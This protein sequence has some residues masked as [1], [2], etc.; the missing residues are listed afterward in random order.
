MKHIKNI[1]LLN[2]LITNVFG[3]LNDSPKFRIDSTTHYYYFNENQ[4]QISIDD[5]RNFIKKNINQALDLRLRSSFLS[6][7]D[8][9]HSIHEQ[10]YNN[11]PIENSLFFSRTRNNNLISGNG[12]IE[13]NIQLPPPNNLMP[14]SNIINQFITSLNKDQYKWQDTTWENQI[15]EIK[16]DS[17][18]TYFPKEELIILKLNDLDF[19]SQNNYHYAYKIS[20]SS[21]SFKTDSM[22]SDS[23]YYVDAMN[24]DLL[25]SKGLSITCHPSNDIND[26]QY[27]LDSLDDSANSKINTNNSVSASCN[28]NCSS[29]N[30]SLYFYGG[31][32]IFTEHK[33]RNLICTYRLH[34]NCTGSPLFVKETPFQQTNDIWSTNSGWPQTSDRR[35]TTALWS[36]R[37]SRDYYA[38]VWGRNSY[39]NQNSEVGIV[40]KTNGNAN[41]Q[42]SSGSSGTAGITIGKTQGSWDVSLD[43]I[44]HEFSHGINANTANLGAS[45]NDEGA[46]NEGFADIF[47]EM[48]EFY[49]LSRFSFNG[50]I[51]DYI[52]GGNYPFTKVDFTRNFANPNLYNQ[53]S[54][55]NGNYYSGSKQAKMGVLNLWFYLLA[56]SGSGTN[57]NGNTYCVNGIGR[58]KA[59]KIAY[60]TLTSYIGGT[61]KD[62]PAA[63]YASIQ[64]AIDLYGL[65]SPEVQEVIAAWYAVGVGTSPAATALGYIQLGNKTETSPNSYHYNN[66]L[67][68]DLYTVQPSVIVNVSSNQEIVVSSMHLN[69]PI[70]P[71][72]FGDTHFKSGS[73]THLYIAPAC[74]GGARMANNY[75]SNSSST[76]DSNI[77]EK[78]N[79][80]VKAYDLNI[81]PNPN[82]G[83]FT[84][85]LDNQIELPKSIV[86]R[87][88]M[89]KEIKTI[90]N[91][92]LY[93]QT[94]DMRN[95]NDGLYIIN[96]FYSDKTISKRIVKN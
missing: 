43:I 88:N 28:G 13:K 37:T 89:G 31:K 54:T 33:K 24:G 20:I 19:N 79:S 93:E 1:I 23:V 16:N 17:T 14:F 95:L 94:F 67:R 85:L 27:S 53:A 72:T 55:Y 32:T 80:K 56:E 10:I 46:I 59:E 18:A 6:E 90:I 92:T 73:E 41:T 15:K 47:G 9:T 8:L 77:L 7:N 12:F 29:N 81:Y 74:T 21:L 22:F 69:A 75:N 39:D 91:P 86:V 25:L 40:I 38:D 65:V 44:G 35:G 62:F 68:L 61:P 51:A 58:N 60:Y 48:I 5:F 2:L 57:D 34:D 66:A 52:H 3:Q 26:I 36:L 4:Q 84:L 70:Y 78:N 45:N 76:K 82:S 63:R 11:I 96:V 50:P 87:D 49:A 83:E 64:C 42:W 71:P 30:V